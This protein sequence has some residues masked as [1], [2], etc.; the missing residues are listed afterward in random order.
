MP[1]IRIR[2]DFTASGRETRYRFIDN[3]LVFTYME[4]FNAGAGQQTRAS[5]DV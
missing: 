3:E 2:I 5:Y 1:K 4:T